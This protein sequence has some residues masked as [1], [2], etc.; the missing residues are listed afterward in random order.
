MIIYP[1]VSSFIMVIDPIYPF[2]YPDMINGP[3][4]QVSEILYIIYSGIHDW[5]SP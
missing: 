5:V 3:T 4:I 1:D 2:M